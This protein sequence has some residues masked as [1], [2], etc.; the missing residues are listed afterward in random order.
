MPDTIISATIPGHGLYRCTARA[1]QGTIE[2]YLPTSVA[3]LRIECEER[4]NA[5]MSDITDIGSFLVMLAEWDAE[6]YLGASA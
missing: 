6:D 4:A 1:F 3:K 2:K 5:N